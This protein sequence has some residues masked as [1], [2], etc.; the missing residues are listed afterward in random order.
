M[1]CRL[2][3][4]SI[5]AIPFIMAYRCVLC[6]HG[7]MPDDGQWQFWVKVHQQTGE[8]L[9]ESS[10]CGMGTHRGLLFPWWDLI[11]MRCYPDHFPSWDL[12]KMRCYPDKEDNTVCWCYVCPPDKAQYCD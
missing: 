1:D 5:E 3:V 9:E 8:V 10:E 2:N 11:K 4:A 12:K 6:H 7:T